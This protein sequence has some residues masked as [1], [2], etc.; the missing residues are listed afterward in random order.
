MFLSSY[1]TALL[2]AGTTVLATPPHLHKRNAE[3]TDILQVRNHPT[4]SLAPAPGG[5]QP[6]PVAP[7]PGGLQ[8]TPVAPGQAQPIQQQ[9]PP[10]GSG[11]LLL[12][13]A[14]PLQ[15]GGQNLVLPPIVVQPGAVQPGQVK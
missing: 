10:L 11:G 12:G 5:L 14:Q 6:T 2:V 15:S 1:V 9:N 3:I 13:P 8:P 4:G 7:I